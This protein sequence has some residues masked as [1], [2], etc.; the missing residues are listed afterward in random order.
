MACGAPVVASDT[1]SLPELVGDAGILCPPGDAFAFGQALG[2]V[3]TDPVVRL[4]LRERGLER[5]Q[6][7]TWER[8]AD[9][10]ESALEEALR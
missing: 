2:S 1:T 9:G 5:A 10:L 3:L 6:D 4:R 7:F 8:T